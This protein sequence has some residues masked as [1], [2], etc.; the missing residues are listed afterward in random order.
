MQVT[1]RQSLIAAAAT[2]A[3]AT[4][5]IGLTT[6]AG[7]E[8]PPAPPPPILGYE[9]SPNA[10]RGRSS[11]KIG[12]RLVIGADRY[13]QFYERMQFTGPSGKPAEW[14]CLIDTGAASLVINKEQSR[15]LGFNPDR[16]DYSI[17]TSTANG[18]SSQAP[19]TLKSVSIGGQFARRD[20]QAAVAAGNLETCVVGMAFL[21]FFRVVMADGSMELTR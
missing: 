6:L 14:K 18:R 8:S 5:I 3:G 12:P 19:I 15:R 21:K 20:A 4:L 9:P 16:L 7:H 10:G 11:E 13:D 2:A 17:V 1:A